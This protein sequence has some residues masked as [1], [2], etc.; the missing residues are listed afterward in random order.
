MPMTPKITLTDAPTP[1]MWKAIADGLGAF[2][3]SHVGEAHAPLSRPL[4]LLLSDPDSGEIVGGLHGSTGFSYL[5]VN[6]L[7]VPESM[8]GGGI[9][10]Q[11]MMEA[12][13]EAIRRGCHAAV[14]D[15]FSFQARGFYEKLG[16]SVFGTL[17]DYPPG[18]SRFYLTRR[19]VGSGMPAI[20]LR[21]AQAADLAFCR[22]IEHETMRWIIDDLF[23]WD[24]AKQV[25]NFARA[26]RA[27]EVRIITVGAADGRRDAGWLQ[28][29]PD[30][31]AIF[32]K[33]IYLDRPFQRQGIGARVMRIVIDEAQQQS[34]AVTLGVVKI[35][36]ARRLY[37]RLGFYVMED[38]E[39]KFYMRRD[40]APAR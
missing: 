24:E 37:G 23:G 26:W 34:K 35:N 8:R 3:R 16:Y 7:F 5:Y 13:A 4:V 36:P 14:L 17:D 29:A 33:S 40:A 9:G 25:E 38:D 27:E 15:T 21:P 18:H 6:L 2:N 10:R 19:L 1:E 20:A 30:D 28:T 12:E 22:R 31:D 39:Y 11:L 32:V